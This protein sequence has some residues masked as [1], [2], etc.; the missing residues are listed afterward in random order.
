MNSR[1]LAEQWYVP[2]EIGA[3][4]GW[5]P[6]AVLIN[7]VIAGGD[8]LRGEGASL[9]IVVAGVVL[10]ALLRLCLPDGAGAWR[11]QVARPIALVILILGVYSLVEGRPTPYELWASTWLLVPS[12][13]T[14]YWLSTGLS[15]TW[16]AGN[17]DSRVAELGLAR[18]RFMAPRLKKFA[19]HTF[20]IHAVGLV[21]VP[22][23]WI[24]DVAVSPGNILGGAIGDAFTLEHF[25]T[26]L[27]G[28]NFWLWT[29][30]SVVVA[31]G[32]T[33]VGLLLAIPA[34]Y[35][36]SRYN[37]SGRKGSM[38]VFMLIQMFPGIVILVPYFM[39]MKT[40]GL[41]NT[42]IGLIIAY[43]VTALP[44][45]VWM[46]KGFFDA[47]PRALEEAAVLDGCTQLEV[48]FRIVLPLS[49]PAV[50][51]TA[52]F[53]FLT[54]WN[55]FLLA[56]VFNTSNDA[57]TLPVG[58]SSMIPATGQQWGD[59]AAASLVVSIPIVVL[60]VLFQKALIQGLSA[61]SVK[62]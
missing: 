43:S 20:L 54:A 49:L 29:R 62:G 3:L 7:L 30:N 61:G 37:F 22:V 39:V 60:F 18:N 51:I 40:L 10:F 25:R 2:A 44:L 35:A 38:F 8:A 14:L 48:F 4:R 19:L 16:S 26:V 53:S 1:T 21:V 42:S 41:L 5:I 13:L 59:F 23:V 56:L 12:A 31:V 33:I 28:E 57:Y 58:L 36:F 24:L 9:R 34:G 50:A 27:G 46:L 32:T 47:V 45:C 55:E 52:L 11:R 6:F 17:G 15:G